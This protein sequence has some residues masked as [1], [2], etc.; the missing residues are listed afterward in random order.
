MRVTT[1]GMVCAYLQFLQ[2]A[3]LG[4]SRQIPAGNSP[5]TK[6]LTELSPV[7]P[8]GTEQSWDSPPDLESGPCHP[9]EDFQCRCVGL[10]VL[11]VGLDDED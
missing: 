5:S 8:R 1:R 7:G 2:P 10:P 6:P 3:A 9:G 11:D 4:M